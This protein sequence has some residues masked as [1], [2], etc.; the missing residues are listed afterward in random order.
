MLKN[1]EKNDIERGF[2]PR[3][4]ARETF[5]FKERVSDSREITYTYET[6]LLLLKDLIGKNSIKNS[7]TFRVFMDR[8][9]SKEK[10]KVY[11]SDINIRDLYSLDLHITNKNKD[12]VNTFYKL[13]DL[14]LSYNT[15]RITRRI[16]KKEIVYKKDKV[17]SIISIMI[18]KNVGVKIFLLPLIDEIDKEKR[19]ITISSS[20]RKPLEKKFNIINDDDY[21]YIE[22]LLYKYLDVTLNQEKTKINV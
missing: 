7:D 15:H 3:L 1:K 22:H 6:E 16:T 8:E 17:R 11:D 4:L 20:N 19:F 13:N 18:S 12:Y 14:I 10:N 2:E 21:K 5:N 9:L